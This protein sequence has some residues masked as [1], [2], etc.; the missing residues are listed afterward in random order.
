MG[1]S[2]RG[3]CFVHAADLHLDTP[4]VGVEAETPQLAALLRDA[5][6]DALDRLVD[7]ALDRRAAFVVLAGDIYDGSER[8]LRAQLRFRDALVRLDE[9]GIPAFV[10]HGN[11]DP[12]EEGW[13]AIRSWPE[14]V[15]VF[16]DGE[17]GSVPV[18]ADGQRIATVHGISYA[19]RAVSEN[20]A[21]R[22]ERT[23][24]PGV[25][26]GLLHATVGAQPEH[27]TYAPCTID[28]L[29]AARMDYWALGHVHRGQ[30]LRRGEERGDPWVVYPGNTQARSVKPSERGAKGCYVVPIDPDA[31][32]SPIGEPE[33]VALDAVRFEEAVVEIDD[34]DEIPELADRLL[35][36]GDQARDEADGRALVLRARLAGRG[37][38]HHELARPGVHDQLLQRLRDAVRDLEPP[39]WWD[40]L[41]VTTRPVLDRDT[42]RERADFTGEL[43]R[44]VDQ[45][46]RDP[47]V[48]G[49]G[50][51]VDEILER[52]EPAP[53]AVP[54]G[55]LLAEAEARALDLLS[56]EG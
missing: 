17:V 7:V 13:Q 35:A 11:H 52:L 32:G 4:F 10:V 29:R 18:H 24:A 5:S 53:Q 33:F 54:V 3:R 1:G 40:A 16:G 41:K 43:V 27:A 50:Q 21:T 19:T 49:L 36:A 38:L 31:S 8:G 9:A 45:L 30:I 12:V 51:D 48:D 2:V 23:A 39:M 46:R 34:V 25:H 55:E 26:V 22:F 15:T 47:E 20:L 42:L 37:P 14:G 28:D 6:L 56:E 44:L